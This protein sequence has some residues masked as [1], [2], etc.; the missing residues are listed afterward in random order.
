MDKTID[1]KQSQKVEK[2]NLE[3]SRLLFA[4]GATFIKGV[5]SIDQLPNSN[6]AEVAFAGRSNVGKSS[7]INSLCNSLK[8]ART[9]NSPGR[10]RELNFFDVDGKMHIVDLPGY[11]YAKVSKSSIKKWN[12][13]TLDYLKGRPKLKRVYILIDARRGIKQNDIELMEILDISA[14]SYMIVLT[15]IDK[16]NQTETIEVFGKT[17]TEIARHPA[18]Y[19][20]IIASSS[21][22]KKGIDIL[23]LN[24]YNVIT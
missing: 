17:K 4:R 7:L 23:Q 13:L 2:E 10:T 24:I 14:V 22:T 3:L 16:I 18:A 6:Q 11:G 15:K 5:V 1:L 9:S 19:P 20:H 8:L 12:K 21:K